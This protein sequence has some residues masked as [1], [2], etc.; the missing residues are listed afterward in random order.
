MKKIAE[1]ITNNSVIVLVIS[2]LLFIVSIFGYVNT[3]VNY[4]ILVYLPD[5]IETIKGENI[6]TDE[7]GLGSYAFVMTNDRDS[8]QILALEEKIKDIK[9]VK[10]VCSIAEV[11]G[12]TIP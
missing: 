1:K 6:L 7:F 11:L 9:N 3:R 5:T 4:D 10:E 2:L 8:E 12:T